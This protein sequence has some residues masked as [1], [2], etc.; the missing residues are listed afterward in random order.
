M[1]IAIV[2]DGLM[3]KGGAEQVAL[4]F[5]KAF[6]EAPIYT[7]AYNRDNT[8]IEFSNVNIKTSLFQYISTDEIKAKKLFFPF[9][10]IASLCLDV[11]KFDIVIL[12]TTYCAKYVK[13]NPKAMVFCYAHNPFRL[14]WYPNEYAVFSKSSG[15][16][17]LMFDLT[18]RILRYIDKKSIK[19][20]N[21]MLT[22]SSIVKSRLEKIYSNYDGPISII[23]PPVKVDNF[24]VAN[25]KKDNFLVVSRFET[26]KRIDLVIE[27]FNKLGFPLTIVGKG[28]TEKELKK[29]AKDNI[30][31]L[32][33]LSSLELS[34]IY[35]ESR[36]I[37]FPQVEDF[38]I[39]PL[40]ANASGLPVIAYG[41]G[42]V[43]DS[44][45]P[46]ES[47]TPPSQAT[48]IFFNEQNTTSLMNAILDFTLIE[49]QFNSQF[50]RNHAE[51]F[52]ENKFI[53]KI[54]LFIEERC[55]S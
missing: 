19:K 4:S 3:C 46:I 6:P 37:I 41:K 21:F 33:D 2:H 26:Y 47:N 50:I 22:N 52:G 44:Q 9:G 24:Y 54:K 18:V 25:K 16:K 8:Y 31:F 13:V 35:A 20:V 7:L 32:K 29:L 30:T 48:A 11:S 55:I 51:K 28:T 43:L 42:G 17:R 45:I 53:E 39:V 12:S 15:L 10:L 36:A 38:G 49:G 1:K 34:R 14:A 5:H 23:P 27:V 40:E